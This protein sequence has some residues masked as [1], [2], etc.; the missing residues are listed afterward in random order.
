[1]IGNKIAQ[2]NFAD[3]NLPSASAMAA[4]L[5]LAVLAPLLFRKR[6][7]NGENA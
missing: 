1:M 4:I 5:T 3:R 7:V 6:D 2:R